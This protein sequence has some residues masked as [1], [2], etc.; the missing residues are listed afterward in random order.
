MVIKNTKSCLTE[1]GVHG[2]KTVIQY[3]NFCLTGQHVGGT[4]T[5]NYILKNSPT[6]HIMN[7]TRMDI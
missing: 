5:V 3:T 1:Q 7:G 6:E 2:L 4:Q